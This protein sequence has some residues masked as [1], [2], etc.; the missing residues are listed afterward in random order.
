MDLHLA[1]H[2]P[3][4]VSESPTSGSVSVEEVHIPDKT[5]T[6][7]VRWTVEETDTLLAVYSLEQYVNVVKRVCMIV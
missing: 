7:R 3:S 6:A 2:S 5:T 4:A 1:T